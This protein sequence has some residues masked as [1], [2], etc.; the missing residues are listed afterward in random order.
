MALK[1]GHVNVDRMLRRI[2]TKQLEEWRVYAD[3]EPFDEERA[4]LRSAQIVQT[5][6]NLFRAKGRP[7]V[8]LQDCKLRFGG[9]PEAA[10]TPRSAEEARA[11]IRRTLDMLT[12]IHAR[13]PRKDR[14]RR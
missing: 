9:T 13:T 4:D 1:L 8:R 6:V 11:Q 3:L 14:G 12:A 2:S 7:S 10:T 5:L